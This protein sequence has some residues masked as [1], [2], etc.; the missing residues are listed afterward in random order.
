M[1]CCPPAALYSDT[2]RRVLLPSVEQ[3]K[4]PT[5]AKRS[6]DESD[7]ERKGRNRL[8]KAAKQIGST[9][10]GHEDEQEETPIQA[11]SA[12]SDTHSLPLASHTD[13]SVFYKKRVNLSIS[14]PPG[15]LGNIKQ[16]MEDSLR[17]FL[18]KYL[19][20]LKG[21][22]MAFEN[23]KIK[24]SGTILNELPHIHYNIT[25]DALVF[26]PSVG[27]KL[28]G[29]VTESFHSH[30]SLLVNGYFNASLAA[31]E[32]RKAGFKFDQSLEQW[33][34]QADGDLQVINKD[35]FVTFICQHM[36]ESV[37]L[38]SLAGANPVWTPSMKSDEG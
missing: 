19:D 36:Y 29:V 24:E 23:I 35:D 25:V 27:Y 33:C 1:A 4:K 22:L 3:E 7:E 32:M 31:E 38:I 11:L 28:S 15:S 20:G 26:S 6:R 13:S 17:R 34:Q 10:S 16:S 8:K 12:R 5:M 30:L 9:S 21:V 37:G 2:I 18:L 14:L